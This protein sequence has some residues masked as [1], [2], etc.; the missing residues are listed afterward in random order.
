MAPADLSGTHALVTGA[1]RGFG[2]A[3]VVALVKAGATVTGVARDRDRLGELHAELGDAFIPVPAD[4]TDP[5][6]AGELIDS[7]RPGILVLNAGAAPL[8]R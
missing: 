6:V 8:S 5:N 2:R 1:S 3:T 7:C 4:A